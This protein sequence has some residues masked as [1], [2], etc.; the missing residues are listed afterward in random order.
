MT[1]QRLESTIGPTIVV[2]LLEFS[3]ATIGVLSSDHLA[4]LLS[5][6]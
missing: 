1:G 3:V 2:L 5:G 6:S 4:D